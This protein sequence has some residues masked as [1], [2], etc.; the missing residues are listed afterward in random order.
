M[1]WVTSDESENLKSFSRLNGSI[2]KRESFVK[3]QFKRVDD[4]RK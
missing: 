1:G 2:F 3:K 4:M